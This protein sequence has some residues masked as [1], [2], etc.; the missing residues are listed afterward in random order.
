MAVSNK[1]SSLSKMWKTT[2]AVQPSFSNVPEGEYIGDLKEMKLEESKKSAR[3]QVVTTIEI[4]DGDYVGK[5]VKRF[6]GLDK[7][8]SIGYFK[9]LCEVIGFDIPE[10]IEL[11]QEALDEF[12]ANNTDLFNITIKQNDKYSNVYINGVSD[13]T[14][15]E[16][17]EAEEE[18]GL[19][20]VSEEEAGE[21]EGK[22]IVN[23]EEFEE[24]VGEEEEEEQE[25]VAP[26][27][28][29]VTKPMVKAPVKVAAPA[30]KVVAQPAK[31]VVT[32]KGR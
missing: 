19:E 1:L 31:K 22:E 18:E 17:G 32:L 27:K 9:G 23:E 8:Q 6:D 10:D 5:T 7:E 4:A 14:K 3:L 15:G 30:K 28:K 29:V 21:E 24:E 13:F 11:L 16:E 12:I 2:Q 26:K 20:E 25:V